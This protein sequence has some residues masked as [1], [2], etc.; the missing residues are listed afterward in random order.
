MRRCISGTLT[1]GGGEN[2]PG[3]PCACATLNFTYLARGPWGAKS[4]ALQQRRDIMISI[5]INTR[6]GLSYPFMNEACMHVADDMFK[7]VSIFVMN[8]SSKTGIWC[9]KSWNSPASKRQQTI[10]NRATDLILTLVSHAYI[11]CNKHQTHTGWGG[12]GR[13]TTH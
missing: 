1:R 4:I 11:S 5:V 13:L 6:Q 12:V 2:V 9:H 10:G 3:I 8:L 7:L